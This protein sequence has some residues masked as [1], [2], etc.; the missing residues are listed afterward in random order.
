MSDLA[1]SFSGSVFESELDSSFLYSDWR[2]FEPELD[3][4][5]LYSDWRSL[6]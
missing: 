4:S 5:F 2:C 3:S 1:V 6:F